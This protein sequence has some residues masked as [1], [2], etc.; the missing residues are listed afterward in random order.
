MY[1]SGQT[2]FIMKRFLWS[3][4]DSSSGKSQHFQTRSKPEGLRQVCFRFLSAFLPPNNLHGPQNPVNI[5]V[6]VYIRG[7]PTELWS[8]VPFIYDLPLTRLTEASNQAGGNQM[9]SLAF[10]GEL[11]TASYTGTEA[12]AHP[13][14]ATYATALLSPFLLCHITVTEG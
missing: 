3:A 1:S 12:F 10:A 8:N 2:L 11:C 14:W 9:S 5:Y 4:S 7:R 13:P 6:S